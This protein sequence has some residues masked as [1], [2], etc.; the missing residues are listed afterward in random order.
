[1]RAAALGWTHRLACDTFVYHEG[2]VSFGETAGKL[3]Q[4]ATIALLDRHPGYTAAVQRHVGRGDV[5]PCRFAITAALF[6]RS[7]LPV[8]LMVTHGQGGGVQRHIDTI[9]QR[10]HNRAH[11]VLLGASARGGVLSVPSIQDH[12]ELIVPKDRLDDLLPVLRAMNV[13]RAHIQ[14]IAEVQLDIRTLIRRLGVKFDVT[15]HDYHAICPQTNMLPWPYGLYCGEP[16]IGGCNACISRRPS[17]KAT[18]IVT[19]R[20]GWAWLF[21]EADRIL[22]PSQPAK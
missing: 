19:W 16:D 4:R 14:H 13:S 3:I 5:Q 10:L 11:V 12:P 18:D 8:I 22:C 9:T 20:A 15:V 7:G 21:D 2:S 17:Y 6:A 1:M